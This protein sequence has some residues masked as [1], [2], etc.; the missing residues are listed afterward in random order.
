MGGSPD[1]SRDKVKMDL[2]AMLVVIGK[3]ANSANGKD[4]WMSLESFVMIPGNP[5]VTLNFKSGGCLHS[6]IFLLCSM[7]YPIYCFYQIKFSSLV[8]KKEK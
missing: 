6:C 8:L 2:F 5:P 3:H 7:I 1:G 4:V